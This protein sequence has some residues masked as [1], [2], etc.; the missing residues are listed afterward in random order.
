MSSREAIHMSRTA[1]VLAGLWQRLDSV[2]R[3]VESA[4]QDKIAWD[5]V[6]TGG[7]A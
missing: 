4:N 6:Q 2:F 1:A 7:S 5:S 3:Y